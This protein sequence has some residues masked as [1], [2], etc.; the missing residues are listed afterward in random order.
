M[1]A[2]NEVFSKLAVRM[3]ATNS[4]RYVRI[5]E[6]QLTLDEGKLLLELGDWTTC[7]QLAKRLNT[8]EK[9]LQAKLDDLV[10]RRYV[11][12]GKG[13]YAAVP[14][15]RSFPHGEDTEETRKLW[16]EFYTSG[17]Y[18][19]ILVAGWEYRLKD[20][21]FHAHKVI[22]A[23][24]ALAASP[25]IRPEQILW[26]EDI[27][28]IFRHARKV[29]QSGL[30]QDGKLTTQGCGCRRT[31]ASC[32]YRAGCTGWEWPTDPE[33]PRAAMGSGFIRKEVSVE[34][35]L[36]YIEDM[37][38][39]GLVHISPNTSQVTSTCNCCPCCCMVLH[40]F[41]EYGNV[42]ETLAP[43]RYRAVIDQ[44]LCNGCQTCV[45]RCHFSAIEMR[46]APNS[47][48]LKAYVI[49]EHCMGCGLCIFKC[50]QQAMHLEL[51]R[52]VEHIPTLP[53]SAVTIVRNAGRTDGVLYDSLGRP[54]NQR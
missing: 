50:E 11:L 43:S 33:G 16:K 1:T 7:E 18:P 13:G 6:H 22:P 15:I 52:P 23:R 21:G 2:E 30:G 42:W 31:W 35:G 26:Y 27:E 47:K 12:C 37:E 44:E 29:S 54:N 46:K 24:R 3:G 40:S 38:E 9:S 4:P 8:D 41:L 36:V 49:N 45:E 25:N 14:N 39:Q 48:K 53:M 17:D 19:K 34:D 5:L 28:Q 32:D 51:V 10:G 20:R